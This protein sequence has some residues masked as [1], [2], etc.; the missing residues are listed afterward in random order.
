MRVRDVLKRFEFR[1]EI[2]KS[3]ARRQAGFYCDVTFELFKTGDIGRV[4]G[5]PARC[6]PCRK[7]EVPPLDD[8]EGQA[9]GAETE[10]VAF[11]QEIGDQAGLGSVFV[12]R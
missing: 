4:R 8:F 3:E 11:D 7:R 1:I 12:E 6:Q 9:R 5:K 10:T 2:T